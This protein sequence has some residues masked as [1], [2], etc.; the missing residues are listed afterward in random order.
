M[1]LKMRRSGRTGN[2][3]QW[4]RKDDFC[5]KTGRKTKS[6]GKKGGAC[7]SRYIP[8]GS[9]RTVE[10]NGRN[11]RRDI[12]GGQEGSEPAAVVYDA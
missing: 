6:T 10:K 7:S 11:R 3:S 2:W 8:C 12:I 1:N 5:R 4:C 9:R